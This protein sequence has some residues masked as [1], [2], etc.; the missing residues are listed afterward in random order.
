M[1]VVALP[2]P[3]PQKAEDTT[4]IGRDSEDNERFVERIT[5]PK[6]R[7]LAIAISL[8]D[9]HTALNNHINHQDE[10]IQAIL[11]RFTKIETGHVTDT[12]EF[13]KE[14][15]VLKEQIGLLERERDRKEAVRE[16]DT[17]RL[18]WFNRV[19]GGV[20]GS[21]LLALAYWVENYLMGRGR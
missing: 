21:V 5:N 10:F 7:D 2:A 12:I 18:I 20:I 6:T 8:R 9:L 13:N 15:K 14:I 11:C 4:V 17:A 1:S 19:F 3:P 16:T